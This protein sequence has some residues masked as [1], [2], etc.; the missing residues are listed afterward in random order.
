[1]KL[2]AVFFDFDGVILDSVTAKTNAFAEMFRQYGPEVEKQVV[3][4]H[5]KNGGISRWEKFR[6]Y[7]KNFLGKPISEAEV[8][9]LGQQFSDIA[10]KNVLAAAFI[11]G[12]KDTLEALKDAGVPAFVASGTPE[13]ELKHV[14]AARGL[15]QYFLEVH[16]APKKKAEIVDDLVARHGFNK[17]NTLFLGDATT[18]HDAAMKAG[19]PFIGIVKSL[20]DSP[21][22]AETCISERVVI[23][24]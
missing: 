20:D 9:E 12:A 22:P 13:E 14:V 17:G 2:E 19:V 1:M 11:P 16:G 6:H 24:L 18:D 4:Y 10:L 5:I 3:D 15:S 23:D 8:R 21:F 7:Y